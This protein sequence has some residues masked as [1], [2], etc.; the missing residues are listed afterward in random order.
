MTV[1]PPTGTASFFF[2][3]VAGSTRLWEADRDGMAASLE[4][5]DRILRTCI[6]ENAGYVFSTAGDAFAAAFPDAEKALAAAAAAQLG[7]LAADWPGPAIKVRM[8]IHTGSAEERGGDYF[9]PVLN[10]AARIMSAGHGGQL[11][12]SS[13]TAEMVTGRVP[14]PGRLVDVGLHS[15]KDL[16][17]PEQLF[18]FRHPDLPEVT[19]PLKTADVRHTNLPEQLTSFVGRSRELD[20]IGAHLTDSRLVTL[21]GVGGTGKTRL[22]QEAARASAGSFDDGVWLAELAPVTDPSL[23]L[24]E[25]AD[26]WGLRA[27]EGADLSSVVN[28]YLADKRLLLVVDNCEHVLDAAS[29][30]VAELLRA[31]PGLRIIATSRESLGV[32]GELVYHVPSLLVAADAAHAADSEAVSLFLARAHTA[33][34]GFS[35]DDADIEAIVRICQRIDG[36]PL[37]VE[38]AAARL[39][40]MDPPQLAERL[41]D[42]FRI[43]GSKSALPRHRTLNTTI[44]WSHDLLKPGSRT[45]FRRLS[46]FAGGFDLLA[47]EAVCSDDEVEDWEIVDRLDDLVDKSL[48]I[49]DHE[50]GGTTRFRLLEPIRQ[51]GAERLAEAGEDA[52]INTAHAGYFL[53]LCR[54]AEPGLRGPDQLEWYDRIDTDYDN[55]RAALAWLLEAGD[56][57]SYLDLCW[58]LSY[59]W[60]RHGFH[61]EGIDFLLDGLES[62]HE[63]DLL[64]RVKGWY[65]ASFLALD[66]TMPVSIEYGRTAVELAEELGEPHSLARAQLILGGAIKNTTYDEEEG[67]KWILAG[68]ALIR[69]HPEPSWYADDPVWDEAN[70]NL[71]RG[72]FYPYEHPDRQA[73]FQQSIDGCAAVGDAAGVARAQI[74]SHFLTGLVDEDWIFENLTRAVETSRKTGFRQE[75]GHALWW[76][77]GHFSRRGG[78]KEARDAMLEAEV[79]LGEVGDTPCE[80]GATINAAGAALKLDLS[81]EGRADLVRAARRVLGLENRNH[82]Q[83]LV[84][85]AT[86]YAIEGEEY[87]LAGRLLGRADTYGFEGPRLEELRSYRET[88]ESELGD[89]LA[90]LIEEGTAWTDDQAVESFLEWTDRLVD[91]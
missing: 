90:P 85:W 68:D 50:A 6:E 33:R 77:A 48:L 35:P 55:I 63:A 84:D 62:A 46:V 3:D 14:D 78:G 25:I 31:A 13:I 47:A 64:R 43:L 53:D 69:E 29:H 80:A 52:S 2:T 51:F 91:S 41:E 83:R 74:V 86:G 9:G 88:L 21:T 56:L 71:A 75:L 15:L 89:E 12:L 20:E 28:T 44:E 57:A 4:L 58:G 67:D 17:R 27:G 79:V 73:F 11:L 24:N 60:Q 39:R 72:A 38:L 45:V 23:T 37:G 54:R 82:I 22:S 1:A 30:V 70:L 87:A 65:E 5:H 49:A 26:I 42:S 81:D 40:S 32:P 8:G 10:R 76:W 59:Y 36:I 7:L 16:D 34:P 61:L 19:D 18:E 66:I